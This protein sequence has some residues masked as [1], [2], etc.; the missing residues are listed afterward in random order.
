MARLQLQARQG[1]ARNWEAVGPQ[2]WNQLERPPRGPISKQR[3]RLPPAVT[4]HV[5][6]RHGHRP[7]GELSP[8]GAGWDWIGRWAGKDG[9]VK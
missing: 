8:S 4:Q 3:P 2:S 5:I 6:K 9:R 1:S 7:L